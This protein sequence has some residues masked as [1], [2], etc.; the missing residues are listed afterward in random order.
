MTE[1]QEVLTRRNP[2]RF[3]A[4]PERF[5][6]RHPQAVPKLPGEE[7]AALGGD[8]NPAVPLDEAWKAALMCGIRDTETGPELET[9]EKIQ[10]MWK[11]FN[12]RQHRRRRCYV[13]PL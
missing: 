6:A 7:R 8:R 11:P 2:G 13:K 10:A 1:I 12:P 5:Y 3:V 4:F 9:N